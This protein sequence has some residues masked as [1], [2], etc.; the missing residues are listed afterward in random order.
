MK[1]EILKCDI[2]SDI[3]G[4]TVE[5]VKIHVVFDHDQEDGKRKCEPYLATVDI[6]ICELCKKFMLKNRRYIY[7]Y[8]AMGY[9]K[10]YL[11]DNPSGA[12]QPKSTLRENNL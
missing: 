10:Y 4:G 7:A 1:K 2:E 3:H 11:Y 6:E 8:G 9:N 5:T 12:F